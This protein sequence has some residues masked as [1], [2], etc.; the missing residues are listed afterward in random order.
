MSNQRDLSTGLIA[1]STGLAYIKYNGTTKT[2]GTFDGGTTDPTNTTRL[3]YDGNLYVTNLFSSSGLV[4]N[5]NTASQSSALTWTAKQTFTNTIKIQQALEK[6]TISAIAATGTIAFDTLSTGILYYT[7][8]ASGN[9]TLNCRGDVSNSLDS[10]MAVGESITF[11]FMV[12]QGATAYYNNA[13]QI[14]GVGVT[15]KWSGG[16]APTSG[17]INSINIY[18]YTIIKTGTATFTVL[19]S[20]AKYA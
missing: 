11:T 20:K 14:D 18:S 19:A 3:N 2:A 15:P 1:G 17:D 12:S 16:T 7:T 4:G 6:I 13:V 8:N 5:I 9:W 10:I